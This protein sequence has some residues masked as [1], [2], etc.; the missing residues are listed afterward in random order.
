M[1]SIDNVFKRFGCKDKAKK[2]VCSRRGNFF[3]F[4][5]LLCVLFFV[6]IEVNTGVFAH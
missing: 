2:C 1:M 5:V 6:A 4:L 3:F